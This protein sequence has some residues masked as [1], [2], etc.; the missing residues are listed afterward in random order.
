MATWQFDLF[1]VGEGSVPPVF[2]EECWDIAPLP[3]ASTLH[4]QE[5]LLGSIG[6]PWLMLDNWIVFGDEGGTRVDFSFY[7]ADEVEIRV[8]L[9][10]LGTESELDAVCDFT[11][12]LRCTLFDPATGATIQPDRKSVASALA[13]SR[14]AAFTRSPRAFLSEL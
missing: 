4:A 9:S 5:I 13:G 6:N 3:A 7:D 14:A 1:L 8:R 2:V 10:A 11:A 12:A